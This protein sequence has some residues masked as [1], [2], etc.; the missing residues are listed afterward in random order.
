MDEMTHKKRT[1]PTRRYAGV[2]SR[3]TPDVDR[4]RM[5]A[6]AMRLARMGYTLLSGGA[7]GADEAFRQGAKAGNGKAEIYRPW[8]VRHVA[9]G[10]WPGERIIVPNATLMQ[11]A[12]KLVSPTHPAW[13]RL[14][15][16]AIKLHS[17]NAMQCFGEDLQQPVDFVLCWTPDGCID[18]MTRTRESGGTATAIV[19]AANHGIPVVNMRRDT[20]RSEIQAIVERIEAELNSTNT[21]TN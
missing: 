12:E 15:E 21:A 7:E 13:N 18:G 20:W 8:P 19:L 6:L 16:T 3:R 4:D 11:Q 5:S 2:G 10:G 17:R 9:A 14:S 1:Q